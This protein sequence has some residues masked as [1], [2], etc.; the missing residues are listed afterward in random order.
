MNESAMGKKRSHHHGFEKFDNIINI[1]A[2]ISHMHDSFE[3]ICH[4]SLSIE[5]KINFLFKNLKLIV[6]DRRFL[7]HLLLVI[8]V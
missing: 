6:L 4:S 5:M 3:H 8:C 1:W 2:L 7:A